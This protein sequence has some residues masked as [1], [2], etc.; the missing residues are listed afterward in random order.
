[1]WLRVVEVS[2]GA[3]ALR[4]DL[5]LRGVGVLRDVSLLLRDVGLRVR[6]F[7]VLVAVRVLAGADFVLVADACV[8]SMSEEGSFS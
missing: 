7:A 2:R 5:V 4:A 1:L 8:R 6:F 3:R